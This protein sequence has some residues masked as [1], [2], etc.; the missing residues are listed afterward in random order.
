MAHHSAT[1]KSIRQTATRNEVNSN[2]RS[3]IRT[4]IK[5]VEEAVANGDK[6]AAK[7]AFLVAQAELS[8][9]VSKGILKAN[10]VSRKISRLNKRIKGIDTSTTKSKSKD[11]TK[12]VSSKKSA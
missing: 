1:L 2:R 4:F 6:D 12:K 7:A 11:A 10:T 5:K 9:G 3:R 8:R